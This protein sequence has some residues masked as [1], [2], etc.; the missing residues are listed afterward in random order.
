[1]ALMEHYGDYEKNLDIAL[2]S[3]GALQR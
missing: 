3:E 2:N 1:M